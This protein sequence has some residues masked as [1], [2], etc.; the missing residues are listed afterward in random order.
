MY[1]NSYVYMYICI[2]EYTQSGSRTVAKN[3]RMKTSVQLDL[4]SSLTWPF[5]FSELRYQSQ[6]TQSSIQ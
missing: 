2:Y 3:D 4:Q 1:M 6:T 5:P